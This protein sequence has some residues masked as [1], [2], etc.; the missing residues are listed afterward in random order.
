MP[1]SAAD[2]AAKD[3]E[4]GQGARA[5]NGTCLLMIHH[6]VDYE[7][8]VADLDGAKGRARLWPST[9]LSRPVGVDE[10]GAPSA[11]R[12]EAP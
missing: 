2:G 11:W 12:C 4:R 6:P 3:G 9:G 7:Y 1:T 10:V 8:G 5:Y